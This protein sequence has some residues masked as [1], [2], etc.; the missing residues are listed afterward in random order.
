MLQSHKLQRL[1]LATLLASSL[2]LLLAAGAIVQVGT[3]RSPTELEGVV[4]RI[5]LGIP[6]TEA[7]FLIGR[8]PDEV[9]YMSGTFASPV[10][11]LARENELAGKHGE[12][13]P[14]VLRT[15]REGGIS[16][17]VAAALDGSVS[18]RWTWES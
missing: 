2:A 12:V 4:A 11:M 1:F 16:A 15:W 17:T 6:V 5:P 10:T 8:A 13:R 14:Y 18:G 7:E 9:S 3:S